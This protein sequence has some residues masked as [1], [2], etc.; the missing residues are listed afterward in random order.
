MDIMIIK[1]GIYGLCIFQFESY[2]TWYYEIIYL[3]KM[4]ISILIN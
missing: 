1:F 4:F 2:L 3:L